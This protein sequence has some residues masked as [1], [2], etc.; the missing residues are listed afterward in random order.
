MVAMQAIVARRLHNL[1]QHLLDLMAS[2]EYGTS[3]AV[4]RGDF[5]RTVFIMLILYMALPF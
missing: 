3:F 4:Q 5:V 1:S 2:L